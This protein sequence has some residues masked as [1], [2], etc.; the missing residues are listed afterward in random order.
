MTEFSCNPTGGASFCQKSQ[1]T[2]IAH[3]G[4][5]KPDGL[6]LHLGDPVMKNRSLLAMFLAA[7]TV[8]GG[9]AY[10]AE[11]AAATAT[12]SA[13]QRA[14]DA[15]ALKLS[16]DGADAFRDMHRARV[17]IFNADPAQA[18]ALVGKAQE[19][20]GKAKTDSSVF[21]KAEADLR[22]PKTSDAPAKP[23]TTTDPSKPSAWLPID[24]QMT[25][26]EDFVATPQK[27]AAVTDANKS[28]A[29]G[30]QKAA[31]AKLKLAGIDVNF[32]LAVAPLDRTVA[33]VDQAGTL[34]GQGKFYEANA[35]LKQAEDGVRFDMIDT[36]AVPVKTAATPA[37]Q[38]AP[39]A[40]A[41][42]ATH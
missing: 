38:T 1:G 9:A 32:T 35:V 29:Q 25:L 11:Q 7:S 27:T 30:D 6:S 37:G 15:D 21:Q 23:S 18:K 42:P 36:T 14:V 3:F 13:A 4:P 20:L 33:D 28:L 40:A 26:A 31:L 24:G 19:A 22:A 5:P 2:T 8:L 17:A 41:K 39:T 16:S 34:I 12:P 10:A